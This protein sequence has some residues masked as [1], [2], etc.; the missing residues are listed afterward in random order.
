MEEQRPKRKSLR[1]QSYDYSGNGYY[2]ITVCTAVRHQNILSTVI[3]AVG[4]ITNRPPVQ[5]RLTTWG[6]VVERA[7]ME[8]PDHYPGVT[9]DCYVIMPDHVHL[10]LAVQQTGPDGRQIAAP[11]HLSNIIQQFKRAV[12]RAVGVS[13]WQKSYYDHIIRTPTDLEKTRQYIANNPL[14]RMKEHG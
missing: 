1:L 10:I 8:I 4:A 14:K 6:T 7:I 3:P 11:T 12:S 5:V 9:V 13:I 2:F